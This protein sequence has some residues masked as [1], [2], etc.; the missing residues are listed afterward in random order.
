[1]S[2][3]TKDWKEAQKERF[4][5]RN[6]ERSV[7]KTPEG[8]SKD[9]IRDISEEKGEPDWMLERRLKS[10]EHFKRKPMP[11]WGPSLHELD[12]ESIVPYLKADESTQEEDWDDVPDDIKDT[13][14][15]LGIPEA[16]REALGGVGA[17]Y[18]SE[19]VYQNMK[20]EW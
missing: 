16:E 3:E 9:V 2:T 1:M 5:H 12:I 14:E 8:L 11:D 4:D 18:E 10:F 19:V 17:Q 13:F 15:K 7:F 6:P 20:E